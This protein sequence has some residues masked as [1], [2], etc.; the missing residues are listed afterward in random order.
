MRKL[1]KT[2]SSLEKKVQQIEALMQAGVVISKRYGFQQKEKENV[3]THLAK[4]G[5]LS[6]WG[7]ANAVTRSAEDSDRYDRAIEME[8][9]GGEIIELSPSVFN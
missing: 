2:E 1:F 5:D 4:G 9:L 8:R 3:L 6:L 7:L